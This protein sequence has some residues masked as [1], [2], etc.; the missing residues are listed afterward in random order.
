MQ[1]AAFVL[2]NSRYCCYCGFVCVI[3]EICGRYWGFRLCG[4]VEYSHVNI[5]PQITQMTQTN[6]ASCIITQR[7]T[8]N[9]LNSLF[10]R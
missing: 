6:A 2:A 7:N 10:I 9:I 5:L 3:S 1:Q 4:L 8:D